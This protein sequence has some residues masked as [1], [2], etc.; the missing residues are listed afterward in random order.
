SN[1]DAGGTLQSQA[2]FLTV[3][4]APYQ[5]AVDGYG[6]NDAGSIE[7]HL[8]F[9]SQRP[10]I[11]VPP[12]TLSVV[13][14]SNATFSVIARGCLPLF[15]QWLFA[16]NPLLGATNAAL[17]IASAQP[18]DEGPYQVVVSNGQGA[19][20]SVLATLTVLLPPSIVS[21]P[22]S[23]VVLAGMDHTFNVRA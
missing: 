7:F 3:P 13:T 1:D 17:A 16:G 4:G 5:I 6:T 8:D 19:V 10:A 14:G 23:V 11:L 12:Q 21:Q 15:Y 22:Q 9:S 18:P 20:T 2:S